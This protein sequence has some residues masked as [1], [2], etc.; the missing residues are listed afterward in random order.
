M[1]VFIYAIFIFIIVLLFFIVLLLFINLYYIY[2]YI[3]N[4][5]LVN[6]S[7]LKQK[8]QNVRK[9]QKNNAFIFSPDLRPKFTSFFTC[10]RT[11]VRA[12]LQSILN[13]TRTVAERAQRAATSENTCKLSKQLPQF[14]NTHTANAHNTTKKRNPLQIEKKHLQIKTTLSSI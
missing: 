2:I 1:Y 8:S 10:M 13:L 11:V 9:C 14:N 6:H 5:Y 12:A 3:Y 7:R 4:I